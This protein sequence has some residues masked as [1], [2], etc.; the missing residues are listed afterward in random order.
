MNLNFNKIP[1]WVKLI[2]TILILIIFTIK[3]LGYNVSDLNDTIFF[4]KFTYV[5]S[6]LVIFYEILQLY[7]VHVF[8]TR[9][10]K[11]SQVLPDF[12][13]NWLKGLK[14]SCSNSVGIQEFKK[15]SYI[16]ISIYLIIIIFITII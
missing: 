8:S 1:G 10:V 4:K 9:K 15:S 2:F 13:I 5:F 16:E 14:I 6:I 7:L 12:I 11:I 3:L